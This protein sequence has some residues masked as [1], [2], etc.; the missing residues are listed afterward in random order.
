MLGYRYVK[1]Q[2]VVSRSFLWRLLIL[3]A[4]VRFCVG[5]PFH[6]G[7]RF[8]WISAAF[9]CAAIVVLH[10]VMDKNLPLMVGKDILISMRTYAG[11]ALLIAAYCYSSIAA[12]Y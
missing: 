2:A 3:G 9:V 12:A 10:P 5:P 8:P 6:G 11:A 7:S 1:V 4:G